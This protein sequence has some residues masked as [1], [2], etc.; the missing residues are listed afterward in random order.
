MIRNSWGSEWGENGYD[1]I[2]YDYV[3][4]S[5]AEDFWSVLS[6]CRR[7]RKHFKCPVCAD[8]GDVYGDGDLFK[9]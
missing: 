9:R 8:G 2:P 3:L 7:W 6:I 4:N 1:W 5:L